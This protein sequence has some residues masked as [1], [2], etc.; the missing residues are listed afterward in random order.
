M[1]V[2]KEMEKNWKKRRWEWA[3]RKKNELLSAHHGN[4]PN[5]FVVPVK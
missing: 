2:E 1:K 4:H 5:A 3:E